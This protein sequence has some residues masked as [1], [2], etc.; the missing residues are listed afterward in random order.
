[1][2]SDIFGPFTRGSRYER[3][4]C[5]AFALNVD[6]VLYPIIEGDYIQIMEQKFDSYDTIDSKFK[7]SLE[8]TLFE[9]GILI[10]FDLLHLRLEQRFEVEESGYDKFISQPDLIYAT[11]KN[12][13]IELYP[14]DI[15]DRFDTDKNSISQI[16]PYNLMHLINNSPYLKECVEYLRKKFQK[17]VKAANGFFISYK[18]ESKRKSVSGIESEKRNEKRIGIESEK[19]KQERN[20]KGYQEGSKKEDVLDDYI[21]RYLDIYIEE[22]SLKDKNIMLDLDGDIPSIV[23]CEQKDTNYKIS[24]DFEIDII[25]EKEYKDDIRFAKNRI[26]EHGFYPNSFIGLKGFNGQFKPKVIVKYYPDVG[27]ETSNPLIDELKDQINKTQGLNVRELCDMFYDEKKKGPILKSLEGRLTRF[28]RSI[29]TLE[30]RL[31][32]INEQIRDITHRKIRRYNKLIDITSKLLERDDR[33]KSLDIYKYH[34]YHKMRNQYYK[35]IERLTNKSQQ[36]ATTLSKR[37]EE[38]YPLKERIISIREELHEKKPDP[39]TREGNEIAENFRNETIKLLN[40]ELKKAEQ[41]LQKRKRRDKKLNFQS[42]INLNDNRTEPRIYTRDDKL[43]AN[44]ESFHSE[45]I[46]PFSN[47]GNLFGETKEL[48]LVFEPDRIMKITTTN[49][50][51]LD[52]EE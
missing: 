39:S 14:I 20:E 10:A 49:N 29:D 48:Y 1:M 9:E 47:K 37:S 32:D 6:S 2:N 13:H 41:K 15:K 31:E 19:R 4:V 46:A 33:D 24:S 52:D 3:E 22:Q 7:D 45:A 21:K 26:E 11:L 36:I 16:S 28:K 18:K 44:I 38:I 27:I 17:P 5:K 34:R 42:D 50:I 25:T 35:K 8:L 12:E 30:M 40:E 51:F 43:N 23:H